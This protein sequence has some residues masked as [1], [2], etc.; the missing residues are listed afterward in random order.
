MGKGK[1]ESGEVKEFKMLWER[2]KVIV[3]RLRSS[4]DL[5]DIWLLIINV[6]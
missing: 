6:I 2:V 1:G 3:A 5:Q 4:M